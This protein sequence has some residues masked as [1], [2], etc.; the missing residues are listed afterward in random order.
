MLTYEIWDGLSLDCCY[1]ATWGLC[2]HVT[3]NNPSLLH[4]GNT[5]TDTSNPVADLY[6]TGEPTSN[7]NLDGTLMGYGD[8]NP[9]VELISAAL[10]ELSG[11][12]QVPSGK[13]RFKR[14]KPA[15][16]PTNAYQTE[17]AAVEKKIP[18]RIN[19]NVNQTTKPG[20]ALGAFL[21]NWES[22]KQARQT[23]ANATTWT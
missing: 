9:Q 2:A 4:V 20:A 5:T 18:V 10:S 11:C 22:P 17:P 19:L 21:A 12:G 13:G 15:I 3:V 1:L 16:W 8:V 7:R 14:Q 23:T 6:L